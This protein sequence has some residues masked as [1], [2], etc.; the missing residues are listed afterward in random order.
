MDRKQ[1]EATH[2]PLPVRAI[3]RWRRTRGVAIALILLA[4]ASCK[5]SD[6][7]ELFFYHMREA[8]EIIGDHMDDCAGGI[9]ALAA[10]FQA[11]TPDM[12]QAR[13]GMMTMERTMSPEEL[14]A[15]QTR[16][17]EML[18]ELREDCGAIASRFNSKCGHYAGVYDQM[19]RSFKL[20]SFKSQK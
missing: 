17:G 11:N 18:V 6:P 9:K 13:S 16:M 12:R 20:R 15:Y 14:R 7:G 19:M 10:Y 1:L 4:L 5:P 2:E 3:V 8:C